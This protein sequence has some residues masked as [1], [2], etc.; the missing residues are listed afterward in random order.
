[1]YRFPERAGPFFFKCDRNN[2]ARC[3]RTLATET[4]VFDEA[5]GRLNGANW[6][7][8]RLTPGPGWIHCCPRCT[9]PRG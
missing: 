3:P 1:M 8:F 5:R 9:V 6:R 7:A 4:T 2:S